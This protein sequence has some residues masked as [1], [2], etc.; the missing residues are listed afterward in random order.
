MV[1]CGWLAVALEIG[2]PG[3]GRRQFTGVT[4]DRKLVVFEDPAPGS[5]SA[6]LHL[7]GFPG[8]E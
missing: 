2:G 7:L 8:P 1:D 4:A 6:P 5:G 3:K